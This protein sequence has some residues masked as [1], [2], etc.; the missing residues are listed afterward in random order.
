MTTKTAAQR[1]RE[2]RQKE[3]QLAELQHENRRLRERLGLRPRERE[4][5]LK[6]LGSGLAKV[7]ARI[8]IP[9]RRR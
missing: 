6:G 4:F 8:R 5:E 3:S 7:A 2:N 9:R 1:L